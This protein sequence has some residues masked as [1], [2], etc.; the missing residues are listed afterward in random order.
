M[1]LFWTRRLKP[2][3]C[4]ICGVGAYEVNCILVPPPKVHGTF[5]NLFENTFDL[6]YYFLSINEGLPHTARSCIC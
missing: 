2:T 5:H 4:L 6:K 1:S 3:L